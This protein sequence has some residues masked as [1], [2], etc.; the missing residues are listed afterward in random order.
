MLRGA[1]TLSLRFTQ[2]I[3][4]RYEDE[5]PGFDPL[6]KELP[7]L[8]PGVTFPLLKIEESEWA[9]QW[10]MYNNLVHLALISSDDLVQL[11]AN[12]EVDARWV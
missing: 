9:K 1:R 3:A 4:L 2:V 6:P 5:C 10:A 7:M 8:K 11:V 12:P